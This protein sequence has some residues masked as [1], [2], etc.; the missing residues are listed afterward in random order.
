ML[1]LKEVLCAEIVNAIRK[2]GL[3]TERGWSAFVAAVFEK[4]QHASSA[5]T[6]AGQHKAWDNNGRLARELLTYRHV[7]ERGYVRKCLDF[8]AV[9]VRVGWLYLLLFRKKI[10]TS[11]VRPIQFDQITYIKLKTDVYSARPLGS[12]DRATISICTLSAYFYKLYIK[13]PN[14]ICRLC[15][16]FECFFYRFHLLT[17]F[18]VENSAINLQIFFCRLAKSRFLIFELIFKCFMDYKIAVFCSTGAFFG[19]KKQSGE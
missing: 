8:V 10:W 13:S 15:R 5:S 6:S 2:S 4:T 1:F 18:L 3:A 9:R 16:F 14:Y 11:F 19:P 17:N 12:S 7:D